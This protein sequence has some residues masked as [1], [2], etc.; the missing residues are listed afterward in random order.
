MENDENMNKQE[1]NCYENKF[2]IIYLINTFLS[3]ICFILLFS[4]Y[5]G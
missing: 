3:L 5:S 2:R 4:I 1:K